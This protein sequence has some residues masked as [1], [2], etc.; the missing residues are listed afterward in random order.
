ME[1]SIQVKIILCKILDDNIIISFKVYSENNKTQNFSKKLI[2]IIKRKGYFINRLFN[3]DN[4]KT[5]TLGI[6]TDLD[7]NSVKDDDY[8]GIPNII[9]ERYK[10]T[11]RNEKIN[12]LKKL[13]NES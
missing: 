6:R 4:Y 5:Y 1:N 9:K 2:D 11:L 7:I 13:Y 10:I 3:S 12:K 8:Y